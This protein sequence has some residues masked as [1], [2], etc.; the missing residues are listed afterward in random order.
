MSSESTG[1]ESCRSLALRLQS[2]TAS[3]E[4][5]SVTK[6]S[7][8]HQR[9]SAATV[10]CRANCQFLARNF[11]Q[12][13]SNS[14]DSTNFCATKSKAALLEFR[15][16]DVRVSHPLESYTSEMKLTL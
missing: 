2:A 11:T 9:T 12:T 7:R 15:G 8:I 14:H 16:M 3:K 4:K 10:F 5:S 6:R 13:P 1:P